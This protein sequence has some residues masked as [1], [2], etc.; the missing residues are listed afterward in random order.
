V[1]GDSRGAGFLRGCL[2]FAAALTPE[3]TLLMEPEPKR[4]KAAGAAVAVVDASAARHRRTRRLGRAEVR[5]TC[6]GLGGASLGDLFLQIPSSQ[7]LDTVVRA[8]ELGVTYFDTAPWYGLGLSEA[9]VGLA[10]SSL[11]RDSYFLSTKVGRYLRPHPDESSWDSLGW[12]GGLQNSISFA[13]GYGDIMRQ[14]EDSLQ[15]LGC[16][17]VD[18]LVIHDIEEAEGQNPLHPRGTRKWLVENAVKEQPDR[19]GYRALEELRSSGRIKAFGAGINYAVGTPNR[20][21]H[22]LTLRSYCCCP[23]PTHADEISRTPI[24]R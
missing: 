21:Y 19:G 23:G 4:H 3:L 8:H 1:G 9:R 20:A 15:R 6:L 24:R 22:F 16:G 18:C 14:H 13:Y 7:A 2:V 11:R 17:R 12:A 5:A 10:L